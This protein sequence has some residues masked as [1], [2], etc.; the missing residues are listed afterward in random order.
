MSG[1]AAV[2]GSRRPLPPLTDEHGQREAIRRFVAAELRP[3][4]Q[5]WEDAK[6]FPNEG[7]HRLAELGWLGLKY[8]EEY[9]GEGGDYC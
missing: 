5:E 6:W 8:P 1:H 7:F 3:H 4:A 2:P 9:N